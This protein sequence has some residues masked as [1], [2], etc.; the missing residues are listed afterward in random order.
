V[1][2]NRKVVSFFLASPGD[3]IAERKIAKQV[4]DELNSMLSLKFN[5]HIE[6]VGWEDTVSSAGRPQEIINRDLER[7]DVFIGLL[8]KRWGTAPDNESRFQ[9]GFEEEFAIAT[10][11][12]KEKRKPLISLFFKKI[13]TPALSDPGEQLQKVL[14]FR[15]SVIDNKALLFQT[16]ESADEFEGVIRKCISSYVFEHIDL[17]ETLPQATH[18]PEAEADQANNEQSND[19]FDLTPIKGQ[20]ANFVQSVLRRSGDASKVARLEPFEVARLR[21]ISNGLGDGQNDVV[22]IG[23]HDANLIY[24][25]KDKCIFETQELLGLLQSGAKNLQH[26]NIPLWYWL[27]HSGN[28]LYDLGFLTLTIPEDSHA[29]VNSILELMTLTGTKIKEGEYLKRNTYIEIW[30]SDKRNF[31]TKN[32]TLRYLC[33]MGVEEDLAAISL[34]INK[35]DSQTIAL[36]NEAYISIKLR[37]GIHAAF[38]AA[39]KLQPATLSIEIINRLFLNHSHITTDDL[40]AAMENRNKLIR[41]RSIELLLSRDA[42]SP[43]LIDAVQQDPDPSVRAL[44]ITAL[45]NQKV[46]LSEDEAKVIVMKD[47]SKSTSE[48]DAVWEK[49]QPQIL[50]AMDVDELERKSSRHLPLIPDAYIELCRRDVELHRADLTRNLFDKYEDFYTVRM[51]SWADA[52]NGDSE[53]VLKQFESLKSHI[54]NGFVRKSL[55]VLVEKK[56]KKDILVVRSTLKDPMVIPIMADLEYFYLYGEW[57]DVSLVTDMVDRFRPAGGK[58]ILSG[59]GVSPEVQALAVKTILKLGKN[60]LADVLELDCSYRIKRHLI[61][62]IKDKEFASIG[63]DVI[64][65][66]LKNID[67]DVRKHCSLKC[68]KTYSKAK[69]GS[70]LEKYNNEEQSYYNVIYWLDFGL[71]GT[72]D[73]IKSVCGK[74]F[75][76]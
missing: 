56:S 51:R 55:A 48:E 61:S 18:T 69:L 10:S 53:A 4:A 34:E 8:W 11:G 24:K 38:E 21:L 49:I 71:Y 3:L 54:I 13:D 63:E 52:T 64:L 29:I 47:K 50:A 57:Q 76:I 70:L 1:A 35:N 43:H 40:Y 39:E 37:T 23:P 73:Q 42:L 67:A 68:A 62:S 75:I 15:K 20:S 66:I 9:S 44:A 14:K 72:K 16:F 2:G 33:E 41:E 26:E 27:Q 31:S 5:I 60:R 59:Y 28:K 22:F 30:F 12:H 17:S 7:C 19:A 74:N 36:A 6:L 32:A 46:S 65:G 45:L 58:T 25:N